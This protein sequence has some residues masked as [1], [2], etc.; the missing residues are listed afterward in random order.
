MWEALV[1]ELSDVFGLLPDSTSK[2]R[3]WTSCR[4]ILDDWFYITGGHLKSELFKVT[5]LPYYC[6]QA[7]GCVIILNLIQNAIDL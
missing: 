4:L 1:R 2:G 5:F 6:T 3:H 7:K